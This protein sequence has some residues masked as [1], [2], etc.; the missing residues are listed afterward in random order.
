MKPHNIILIRPDHLGDLILSLPVAQTLKSKFPECRIT[1]LA[2]CGPSAIAP[3]VNYVDN[4]LP[5]GGKNGRLSLTELTSLFRKGEYDTLIELLPSWRTAIAGFRAGIPIRIGTS[6]RFYSFLYNRRFNLR[7]KGMG[8]HQTDLDLA[9]LRP[10]GID[11]SKMWP[12]LELPDDFKR[13]AGKLVAGN[14][15]EYIV[16]HPGSMGSA[17]NW[18]LDYYRELASLL[19]RKT[20]LKVVITG[21][22]TNQG[23]FECSLNLCGKT[24]IG[25]LAGIIG[26]ARLFISGSTG[27]LHLADALGTRSVAF[28]TSHDNIDQRRWGPRR[29][30][31]G[32]MVAAVANCRSSDPARCTCLKQISP[33]S[34]FQRV[35]SVLTRG[36]Q[37]N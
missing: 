10:L 22:E 15:I 30:P 37:R 11:I 28:F 27:P 6:R 26:G 33:E 23:D 25:E 35:M 34:A 36:D 19:L 32:V 31:E 2:A 16:V 18:P 12:S 5:D 4:W 8:L 17:P 9:L 13:D 14:I 7:R 20:D 3:M 24:N 21:L 1:Y 29:Y